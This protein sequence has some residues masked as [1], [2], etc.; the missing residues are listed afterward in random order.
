M[1]DNAFPVIDPMIADYCLENLEA[2]RSYS[3][4]AIEAL[5]RG[6]ARSSAVY[7]DCVRLCGREVAHAF[8]DLEIK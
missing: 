7:W 3:T 6:D 4:S 1:T 8:Q 5:L 2:V